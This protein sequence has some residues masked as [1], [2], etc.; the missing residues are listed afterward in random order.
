MAV[1]RFVARFIYRVN[2]HGLERLP[3]GGF[4][5]LPNHLTWIDAVILH[6]ACPRAIRFVIYENI[7]NQRLMRP[8]F[9][10]MQAIPISPK[11]AKEAVKVACELIA[12]G[13]IVCIFP[14]GELSRSGILLRLKRG[15]ELIARTAKCPVVPVW[16]DQ[17]WGSIFS[18]EGGKFFFKW[19]KRIPYPV[20]VAFGEPIATENAGIAIVRARMLELG[21]FCFQ[22][23]ETLRAHLGEACI[24]GLRRRQ[25]SVA[26]I[27]GMDHSQIS[28]GTLLAAGIA[29]SRYIARECPH[30]R[31][32][33]VMPAGKAAIIANLAVVLAGK[34]PVNLNFTAGRAAIEAALRIGSIEHCITARA[35]MKRLPDF[36]WPAHCVELETVMPGLKPH[37]VAWR[38]AV[39]LTPSWILAR[40]LGIP[41]IG[42][43][44]EAVVLFTSGSSG[45]PK[46]VVLSHRN[47]LGNVSQFALML[48][49]T[50]RDSL[51]ACLPFFHSFG[52]TVTLWYPLI[53]GM[54]AV[55]FPN[56]LDIVKNAELIHRYKITLFCSTP[57]FL[58][59]YLRKVEPAQIQSLQLIVTGAEKLPNELA[60]AFHARFG[61]E[62]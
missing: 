12:R 54:R 41:R 17:L 52:C 18:F 49:L 61:K 8:V 59:G 33:I 40:L 1:G 55:T 34:V 58:R 51:L 26:A 7:Y 30:H 11:H 22:Q 47:L 15:Y 50:R 16:M 4:L 31:I 3:K 39:A 24:R 44:D 60:E 14:E 27:D 2:T 62:V 37:I 38:M 23:R 45:D 20:T 35:V 48:N 42:D 32:A 9:E 5:L 36:P 25:F 29:L 28:R 6:L 43:H 53:E 21:E 10:V 46:G 19:P 57:T 56:P 13:E